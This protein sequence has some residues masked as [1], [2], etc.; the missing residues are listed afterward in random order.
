LLEALET[1]LARLSADFRF[2]TVPELLK[3]GRPVYAHHYHR[4][5]E[6]YRRQL[7]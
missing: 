5:P 4:L 3:L 1:L 2:V 6:S 7:A